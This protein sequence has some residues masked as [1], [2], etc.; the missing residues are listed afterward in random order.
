MHWYLKHIR[1]EVHQKRTETLFDENIFISLAVPLTFFCLWITKNISI[2]SPLE[3]IQ[4]KQGNKILW[5]YSA[6]DNGS[7]VDIALF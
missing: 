1:V 6:G 7:Q 2:F 5:T 4:I 3:N